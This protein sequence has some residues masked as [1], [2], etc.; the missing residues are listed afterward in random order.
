VRTLCAFETS[1]RF[2]L[3]GHL[4]FFVI[5]FMTLHAFGEQV[6]IAVDPLKP[7]GAVSGDFLGLSYETSQIL[8]RSDGTHYFSPTNKV[9][10]TLFRTIG[11]KS[12]RIGGNSVDKPLGGPPTEADIDSL[13]GFAQAAG[14]KVIFSVRLEDG[15]VQ[16]A[17]RQAKYI[18]EHYADLLD[19]FA[20]G[21]E[22]SYLKPY[23][24]YRDK[25]KAM[26]DAMMAVAP[27]AKFCGPDTNPNEEWCRKLVEEFGSS[28]WFSMIS[29]HDYPGGASYKNTNAANVK[30]LIPIDPAP[31][32]E[33]MM[34]TDWE[35][36]YATVLK[37]ITDAVAG[38]SVPY[39]MTETNSLWYG[40]L[41]GASD[42]YASAIWSIEYMYWWAEHGAKGL[43]FHTGDR[44]GGGDKSLPSRYTAFVTAGA[45][46]DVHPLSY[47]MKVFDLGG[48]GRLIPVTVV[49]GDAT[50]FSAFAASA[51]GVMSLT[52]LNRSHGAG[53]EEMDVEADLPA[54]CVAKDVRMMLLTAPMGDIA[55]KTGLTLG[56][57]AILPDG[58]WDGKW[59]SVKVAGKGDKIAVR[60][61]MASAAV[62]RAKGCVGSSH[63]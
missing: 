32:R 22:P 2:K 25:W 35:K 47:G 30:D 17:V 11:V 16:D 43:N 20:V 61:P 10:I 45:G 54:G 53:G 4:V 24:A 31:V 55:A 56:G 57:A 29:E 37:S 40:G 39:R 8:V 26:V 48:R 6:R 14:V 13:F 38:T 23:E 60:V 18:H 63:E 27:G 15:D 3:R 52:F 21:N 7:G 19:C 34:S 28:G 9:L 36:R 59:T 5:A 42:S 58:R 1:G 46:Y 12:L 50:K 51:D 33:K 41:E 44:A 62:I 49:S